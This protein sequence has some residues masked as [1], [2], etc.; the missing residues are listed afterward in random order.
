M[1]S[2]QCFF[3]HNSCHRKAKW[4]RR[5]VYCK[6]KMGCHVCAFTTADTVVVV[7]TTTTTTTTTT[8]NNNNN[9]NNSSSSIE[10]TIGFSDFSLY[11]K[12]KEKHI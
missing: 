8:N 3:V 9:N 11:Q 6:Y 7:V 4:K 1:I 5:D 12:E 2:F 10:T